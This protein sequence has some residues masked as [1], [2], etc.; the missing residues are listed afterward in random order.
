MEDLEKMSLVELRVAG[1]KLGMKNVTSFK[2][3]ELLAEIKKIQA[4]HDYGIDG[5]IFDFYWV[6][7]A[8]IVIS[9]P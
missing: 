2:K 9:V 4:A 7:A 3:L 6:F 5:F 1:R 8:R